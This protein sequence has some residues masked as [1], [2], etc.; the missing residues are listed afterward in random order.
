MI[1]INNVTM[2]FSQRTLFKDV[3]LSIFKN[4]KIG[5]TGPNGAG[6]STL[7]SIILGDTQSVAGSV[8]VQRNL[9]IGHLPQESKFHSTKTVMEELTEGDV[10]IRNL[11]DKK[12]KLEDEHRADTEEYGDILHEL[13]HLGIYEDLKKTIDLTSRPIVLNGNM[14]KILE[15]FIQ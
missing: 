9:N 13:E 8:Q 3:T 10:R 2:G 12:R 14:K 15:F 4:E 7:F 6:K 1:N 11:M 5:L